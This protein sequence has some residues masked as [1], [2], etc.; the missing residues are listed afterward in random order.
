[1]RKVGK[2][3]FCPFGVGATLL[4]LPSSLKPTNVGVLMETYVSMMDINST[5][6]CFPSLEENLDRADSGCLAGDNF[7]QD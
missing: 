7:T 6:S 3:S 5:S 1:M 4:V 2:A